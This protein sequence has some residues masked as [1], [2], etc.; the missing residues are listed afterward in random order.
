M[1]ILWLNFHFSMLLSFK[2]TTNQHWLRQLFDTEQLASFHLNQCW[3]RPVMPRF[4]LNQCWPRPMMPSFHLNQCQPRPMMPSFHLNQCWPRPM[5][6]SF[7]LNQCWPRPMMPSF[8]LNQCW[9]RPMMPCGITNPQWIDSAP[10]QNG[11]HSTDITFKCIFLNENVWISI[12]ISLKFVP[13]GPVN[14]IPA[15]VQIMAWHR[16]GNKPLSEPIMISL[17]MHI[18]VSHSLNDFRHE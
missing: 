16:I 11:C 13:K 2:P 1:F 5:M 17:L 6:P 4:H 12:I 8:H 10:R 9:P 14:N 15:F 3:P 7:Y 18:Y